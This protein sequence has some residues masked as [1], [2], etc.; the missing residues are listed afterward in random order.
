MCPLVIDHQNRHRHCEVAVSANFKIVGR[1]KLW[2]NVSLGYTSIVHKLTSIQQLTLSA[3]INPPAPQLASDLLSRSVV[4]TRIRLTKKLAA[5]L[6]GIDV[7]TLRVGDMIELP[8][9]AA[10]MMIAE[11][12]AEPTAEEAMIADLLAKRSQRSDL[13]N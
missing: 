9:S 2:R 11:G 7:S 6:N 1:S 4:V 10:R 12:W 5:I 13:T 3:S 8:D